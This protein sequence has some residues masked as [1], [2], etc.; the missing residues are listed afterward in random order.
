MSETLNSKN[1]VNQ[2]DAAEPNKWSILEDYARNERARVDKLK[3][4]LS[5]GEY[6]SSTLDFRTPEQTLQRYEQEKII[7]RPRI[8][9]KI[10]RAALDILGISFGESEQRRNREAMAIAVE[11]FKNEKAGSEEREREREQEWEREKE[12]NEQTR[13]LIAEMSSNA[14]RFALETAMANGHEGTEYNHREFFKNMAKQESLEREFNSNLTPIDELKL[15]AE[16]DDPRVTKETIEFQGKSIDVYKIS[17]FP[18][19][20]LGHVINYREGDTINKRGRILS[21]QLMENP[22]LWYE[23]MANHAEATSWNLEDPTKSNTLST[24]YVDLSTGIDSFD[25]LAQKSSKAIVYGFD[26]VR[27]T[28]LINAKHADNRTSPNITQ[29]DRY[30]REI[31][32]G[33]GGSVDSID[34]LNADNATNNM[35]NEV[36]MFRYDEKGRPLEPKFMVTDKDVT[37]NKPDYRKDIIK[38]HA[39]AHG[40]PIIQIDRESYQ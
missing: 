19:R 21:E 30:R 18:M 14:K 26:H 7:D 37:N 20:F 35:Y 27:P 38:K 4:N 23:P 13:K 2:S 34:R 5:N 31:I 12:R 25:H 16:S 39:A 15:Y 9:K 3:T 28:S 1:T 8:I 36:A 32:K 40:I 11:E 24:S 29:D 17:G 22:A 33:M 10:G 6:D